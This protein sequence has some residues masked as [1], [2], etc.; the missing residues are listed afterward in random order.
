MSTEKG[1]GALV[2]GTAHA[3]RVAVGSCACT[4]GLFLVLPLI[5]AIHPP[6]KHDLQLTSIDTGNVPPPPPP[7]EEP[8]QEEEEPQDEPPPELEPQE[9][10]PL[11]L[12]QLETLLNPGFGDGFGASDMSL[13]LNN[14]VQAS[15]EEGGLFSLGDLDQKPRVV[16]Q[17]SPIM[18]A[19]MRQR[20]PGS[21]AVIFI[22][23]ESGRVVNPIVQKSSDPIFERA[24]LAA[25]REWRFEPGKRGGKPVR[26][27]YR[28]PITFPEG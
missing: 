24:A 28:V 9:S 17:T 4:G 12:S 5:Q 13:A 27:R 19:K 2:S 7:P 23:D 6:P 22:V 1:L 18:D 8:E 10:Q 16:R 15:K 3:V 11:D 14:V 26:F 25:I 20:A 21:V